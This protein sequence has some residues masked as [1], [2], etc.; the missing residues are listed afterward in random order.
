MFPREMAMYRTMLGAKSGMVLVTGPTGSGK[1][2][3]LYSSLKYLHSPRVNIVTLEDPVEFVHPNRKSTF[4]Q[5]ELGGD[6]VVWK[7]AEMAVFA[8]KWPPMKIRSWREP[9]TAVFIWAPVQA[10]GAGT[11]KMTVYGVFDGVAGDGVIG[12]GNYD[13][14]TETL[15]SGRITIH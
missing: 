4:N 11:L 7:S 1:T 8:V 2:T 5:R 9:V 10:P 14:A 15:R 3:T 6:F 12:N 13:L